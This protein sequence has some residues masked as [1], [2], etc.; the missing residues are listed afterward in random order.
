M[1]RTFSRRPAVS[2]KELI[3]E[4]YYFSRSTHRPIFTRYSVCL[5]V[6]VCAFFVFFFLFLNAFSL[7]SKS[8][9]CPGFLVYSCTKFF[10]FLQVLITIWNLVPLRSSLKN[11]GWE[12]TKEIGDEFGH[13]PPTPRPFEDITMPRGR[14]PPSGSLK[15][16]PRPIRAEET[17]IPQPQFYEPEKSGAPPS[18]STKGDGYEGD[19]EIRRRRAPREGRDEIEMEDIGGYREIDNN[20]DPERTGGAQALPPAYDSRQPR[21]E[22]LYAQ[23]DKSKKKM[24]K[25]QGTE[26]QQSDSWV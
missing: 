3:P 18:T 23:V 8:F 6:C 14:Q 17:S 9:K 16:E 24:Y 22:P 2:V 4:E 26:G 10:F 11:E 19:D 13:V 25:L 15:R 20:P 7:I 21:E 1:K 5:C 12:F